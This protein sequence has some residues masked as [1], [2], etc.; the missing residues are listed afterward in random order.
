MPNIRTSLPLREDVRNK[1]IGSVRATGQALEAYFGTNKNH[2]AMD[3]SKVVINTFG[4]SGFGIRD[5]WDYFLEIGKDDASKFA[6]LAAREMSSDPSILVVEVVND[7][8]EHAAYWMG[9]FGFG[10]KGLADFYTKGVAT[11]VNASNPDG[12][13]NLG[14][15]VLSKD[16]G[17]SLQQ[18]IVQ[19]Y[20]FYPDVFKGEPNPDDYSSIGS[21]VEIE[22]DQIDDLEQIQGF[23]FYAMPLTIPQEFVRTEH[24]SQEVP[25][26]EDVTV[27]ES[28][29]GAAGLL[30]E[31]NES[32][33]E[34]EDEEYLNAVFVKFGP[35]VYSDSLDTKKVIKS[36][37]KHMEIVKKTER[38]DIHKF[39]N[40]NVVVPKIFDYSFWIN[41]VPKDR[42]EAAWKLMFKG[43]EAFD[44]FVESLI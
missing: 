41:I 29:V 31:V 38:L 13:Q 34:A 44:E 40:A 22:S 32:L 23:A 27:L 19:M 16:P 28:I 42:L 11:A 9:T 1:V 24:P 12:M 43:R 4:S 39:K 25:T 20:E 33:D 2:T 35:L 30:K 14:K 5:D 3:L 8:F 15:V 26:M 6:S 10:S 7:R 37:G 21:S 18:F 17:L 36:L